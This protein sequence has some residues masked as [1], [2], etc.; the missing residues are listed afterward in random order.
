MRGDRKEETGI[1]FGAAYSKWSHHLKEI[2]HTLVKKIF[3]VAICIVYLTQLRKCLI[4]LSA[5]KNTWLDSHN[6][7]CSNQVPLAPTKFYYHKLF[8]VQDL[9][10]EMGISAISYS[11]A[12]VNLKV[13]WMIT[14]PVLYY[15]MIWRV[16]IE[17]HF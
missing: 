12:E 17:M 4:F 5:S 9:D 7:S 15:K 13:N 16:H 2:K 6:S 8:V 1:K 3:W 11:L 14:N 10:L